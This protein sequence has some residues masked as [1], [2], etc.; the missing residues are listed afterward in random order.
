[1]AQP[2]APRRYTPRPSSPEGERTANNRRDF[3]ASA[4]QRKTSLGCIAPRAT[5]LASMPGRSVIVS[6]RVRAQSSERV[7]ATHF[8]GSCSLAGLLW[9]RK[10]AWTAISAVSRPPG[11]PGASPPPEDTPRARPTASAPACGAVVDVHGPGPAPS[12]AFSVT[13]PSRA[14]PRHQDPNPPRAPRAFSVP[15]R[16]E[17]LPNRTH[18]QR[19]T[20][21]ERRAKDRATDNERDS[22][23][24]WNPYRDQL[25][26]C[27]MHLSAAL[28]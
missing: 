22:K 14:G 6:C 9:S 16:T 21:G 20:V 3:F 15:S 10:R 19:N 27:A 17:I 5:T 23:C 11:P 28:V 12:F 25:M 2:R 24:D 13:A 4:L 18:E 7:S 8:Q 26:T 1:M